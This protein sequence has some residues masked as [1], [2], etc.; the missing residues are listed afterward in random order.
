MAHGIGLEAGTVDDR[1]L[2]DKAVQ[3]F[4]RRAAQHVAD[5]QVVPGQF[6]HHA[7]VQAMRGIGAAIQVLHEELAT[8]HMRGHVVIQAIKRLCF[9]W[10]VIVPPDAV[11]HRGRA[12]DELV[13][14]RAAGELACGNQKGTAFS[15]GAF[16]ALDRAFY[17]GR[18]DQVVGNGTQPGDPLIFQTLFGIDA[19]CGHMLAP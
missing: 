4:A 17:Q 16:A 14:G 6:G 8:L 5:E 3:F 19:S 1:P 2:G 18:F 15:Q 10:R 11:L 13:L 7:H 12:H 9:H